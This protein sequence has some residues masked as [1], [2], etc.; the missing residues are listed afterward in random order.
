MNMN[1]YPHFSITEDGSL[2]S[3]GQHCPGFPRV[4]YDTLIHLGYNGDVPLYRHCLSKAHGLDMCEVTV[5]TP[6]DPMEL[7]MGTVIGSKLDSTVEQ[8]THA[9]LTSLCE[10]RLTATT[11]MPIALFLIHNQ[12]NPMW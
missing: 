8:M 11:E 7:W 5:M 12:E 2:C 1:N 10:S 9:T 6:F 4:L 3:T